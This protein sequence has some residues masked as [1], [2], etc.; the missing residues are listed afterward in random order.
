MFTGVLFSSS[1]TNKSDNVLPF[2]KLLASPLSVKSM[3]TTILRFLKRYMP[4]A[5]RRGFENKAR[6]RRQYEQY[7]K[8]AATQLSGLC[9]LRN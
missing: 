8:A 7:G 1:S 5:V 3:L 2:G 6:G 4:L 9:E